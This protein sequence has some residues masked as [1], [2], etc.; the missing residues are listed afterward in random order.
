MSPHIFLF[1]FR[2]ILVSRQ[3][4]PLTFY[5]KVAPMVTLTLTIDF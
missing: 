4:V 3:P 2:N 1:I 5:N